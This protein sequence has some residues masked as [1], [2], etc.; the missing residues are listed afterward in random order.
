MIE[1][2]LLALPFGFELGAV[3]TPVFRTPYIRTLPT[4]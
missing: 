4:A 3:A 2:R 1:Q